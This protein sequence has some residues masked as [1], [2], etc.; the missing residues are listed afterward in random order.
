[1]NRASSSDSDSD[2]IL[3]E[4]PPVPV[5]AAFASSMDIERPTS[6]SSSCL[7]GESGKSTPG[8]SSGSMPTPPQQNAPWTAAGT[9]KSMRM[10]FGSAGAGLV[11][12]SGLGLPSAFG[13]LLMGGLGTPSGSPTIERLEVGPSPLLPEQS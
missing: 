9:A 2:D 4:D 11:P 1:M 12:R 8:K 10:S 3:F 7:W 6:S 13:G 5:N